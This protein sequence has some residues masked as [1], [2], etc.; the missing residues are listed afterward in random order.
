MPVYR[1]LITTKP[2]AITK[3]ATTTENT[4]T[5]AITTF[6]IL[7]KLIIVNNY[8]NIDNNI[9]NNNNNNSN[10]NN[11]NNNSNTFNFKR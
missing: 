11:N 3:T 10:N 1:P 5:I 8:N 9:D 2:R 6:N 7:I 4:N